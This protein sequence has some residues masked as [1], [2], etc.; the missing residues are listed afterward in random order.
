MAFGVFA[1][2][3]LLAVWL[4]SMAYFFAYERQDLLQNLRTQMAIV[5]TQ[6]KAAVIFDD[7]D[8]LNENLSA[9]QHMEHLA[10]AVIVLPY[11]PATP[12]GLRM[13]AHYGML[14]ERLD[15]YEESLNRRNDLLSG[16]YDVVLRQSIVHENIHRGDLIVA[17]EQREELTDFLFIVLGSLL[18]NFAFLLAALVIFNRIV[19]TIT[20]PMR[21][22]TCIAEKASQTGIPLERADS[23]FD[24][25][26][27]Q[28]SRSFNFMLDNLAARE[29]DLAKS[30]DELRAL[31]LRLQKVREEER[32]H[33]AHEIHDELGQRMTALKFALMR[34][35]NESNRRELGTAID[36][37]IQVV[38]D[39][40]WSL[41]PSVLDSIGLDAAI[42]WLGKDFQQRMSIRCKVQLPGEA[43]VLDPD[44]ATDVFRIC[45]ELLTNITRHAGA[46]R[47]DIRLTRE[48]AE[49]HLEVRD[50]GVG[51]K[52]QTGQRRS[53]GLLGIEER[54]RRWRGR[55]E[56]TTRPVIDG[57]TVH[58]TLPVVSGSPSTESAS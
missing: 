37:T 13:L 56:I 26:I 20:G 42:D 18:L 24:D 22:L 5:A 31:S 27:G 11:D 9:L 47:V 41:R 44:Q 21:Q 53:L 1:G 50:N 35:E 23:Q 4:F 36:Q 19:G 51:I 32:T 12:A 10:W 38:R 52:P 17:I 58:V 30:R 29:T 39:L 14:P 40:S 15:P 54:A 57:T 16:L 7:R 43:T 2:V 34:L 28:L 6:S 3:L 45:Q 55:V 25:E 33:I 8:V 48:A 46:T 49:L